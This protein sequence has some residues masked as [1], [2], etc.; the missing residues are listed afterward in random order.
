MNLN[1]LMIEVEEWVEQAAALQLDALNRK[2]MQVQTKAHD[3]DFVT[4]IDLQSEKI[5][6][7]CIL[8]RYPDH[9]I[10][11]EEGGKLGQ[12]SEF[13]WVIDPIDGTTNF[14]HG[15][16]LSSISIALQHNGIT[17]LGMVY[18]PPLSMKFQ[19]VR[20]QGAYYN[21]RRIQVSQTKDLKSSL[22]TTGFPSCSHEP[23]INLKYF[24]KMM[25]RVSGIRRTGSAALDLCFVAA[26]YFD[27][28][29]EFDLNAWD[30]C[31]GALIVEEA[32]GMLFMTEVDG[33]P[34][35]ICGNPEIAEL[36]QSSLL[37]EG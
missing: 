29:W 18:S 5:L 4:N 19:A 15:F 31:A 1:N 34:L 32:G 10:W 35:L 9:S 11:T 24:S 33:H 25:G 28:Y 26:S 36:L 23:I 17:Q 3:T 21:R 14:I 16:P 27:G 22:L 12:Q 7:D 30:W 20:G 6:I 2:H 8:K 13:V 37:E